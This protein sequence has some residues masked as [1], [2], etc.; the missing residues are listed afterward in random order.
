MKKAFLLRTQ[1]NVL[2]KNRRVKSLLPDEKKMQQ[3]NILNIK[4]F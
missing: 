3:V 4:F 1:K 2:T